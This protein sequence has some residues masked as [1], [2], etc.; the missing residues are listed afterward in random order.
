M[1]GSSLMMTPILMFHSTECS[2]IGSFSKSRMFTASQNT[3]FEGATKSHTTALPLPFH[4]AP[5]AYA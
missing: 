5:E 2:Q 4:T 1:R 3:Q